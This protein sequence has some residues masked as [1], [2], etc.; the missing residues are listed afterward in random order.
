M[1]S[2]IEFTIKYNSKMHNPTFCD[3]VIVG[4]YFPLKVGSIKVNVF[5]YNATNFCRTK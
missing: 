1:F 3:H 4:F 2:V 5:M